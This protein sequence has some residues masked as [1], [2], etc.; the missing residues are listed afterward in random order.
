MQR[1]RVFLSAHGGTVIGGVT[2]FHGRVATIDSVGRTQAE[3]TVASDLVVLDYDMPHN[4]Y[5]PG[6]VH[7]LYDSGCG[8]IRGAYSANGTAGAGSTTS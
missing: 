5:S 6:C 1:D 3:I 2:M 7:A 8:V 4:L